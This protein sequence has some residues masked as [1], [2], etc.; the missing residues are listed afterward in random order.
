[1]IWWG[2]ISGPHLYQRRS[3]LENRGEGPSA[4]SG[5][6]GVRASGVYSSVSV[7][8]VVC[9]SVCECVYRID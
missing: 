4:A 3:L 8:D 1:M 9:A 5:G 7:D 6:G 2:Q